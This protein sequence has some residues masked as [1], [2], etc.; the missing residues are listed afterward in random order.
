MGVGLGCDSK[1]LFGFPVG[2]SLAGKNQAAASHIARSRA[3]TI[4]ILIVL[5]SFFFE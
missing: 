4:Y 2:D 1:F 5:F 3:I